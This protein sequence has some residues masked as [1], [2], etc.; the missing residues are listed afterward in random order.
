MTRSSTASGMRPP[1]APIRSKKATD[2]AS[3]KTSSAAA[4][5]STAPTRRASRSRAKNADQAPAQ[6]A[7]R[8]VGVAPRERLELEPR[9]REQR[10]QHGHRVAEVVDHRCGDAGQV[11]ARASGTGVEERLEIDGRQRHR[12]EEEV[13][14]RRVALEQ[15]R[16]GDA[17][18]PRDLPGR[19][20]EPALD[21]HLA[22]S[23]QQSSSEIVFRRP[24]DL[25]LRSPDRLGGP[26]GACAPRSAS[27]ASM[28]NVA[29]AVPCSTT[30]NPAVLEHPR[31]ALPDRPAFAPC[32][33]TGP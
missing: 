5:G 6:R 12:R 31:P 2:S 1:C 17:C 33:M 14:L 19:A 9:V 23:R 8:R 22:R 3:A 20:G 27:T 24:I 32:I 29:G 11:I 30:R 15:E 16:L 28:K 25:L 21:E 10:E 7:Q 4:P 13:G 26:T 18:P